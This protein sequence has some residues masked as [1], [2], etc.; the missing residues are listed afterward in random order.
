MQSGETLELC[1]A[2][3][4]TLKHLRM[5]E[6]E[7][8]RLLVTCKPRLLWLGRVETI[9]PMGHH[10]THTAHIIKLAHYGKTHLYHAQRLAMAE[11][12]G[13]ETGGG[14]G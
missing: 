2:R 14:V 12:R 4:A 1:R 10:K 6:F 5:V 8:E 13:L 9:H 3:K 11:N 7:V